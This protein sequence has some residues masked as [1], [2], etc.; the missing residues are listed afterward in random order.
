MSFKPARLNLFDPSNVDKKFNIQVGV[1]N[2]V[3]DPNSH[4]D[5]RAA[6]IKYGDDEPVLI[7]NL[8]AENFENRNP[9]AQLSSSEEGEEG[10]LT[11][12]LN[13]QEAEVFDENKLLYIASS[14]E[15]A[16]VSPSNVDQL[17]LQY[18]SHNVVGNNLVLNGVAPSS[19]NRIFTP[20]LTNYVLYYKSDIKEQP[21]VNVM[22]KLEDTFMM[23]ENHF[24]TM[25]YAERERATAAEGV[26]HSVSNQNALAI[27][28]EVSRATEKDEEHAQDIADEVLRAKAAEEV[29][30]L[31]I[32]NIL[33][34][35]DPAA[36]DSLAE[37]VAKMDADELSLSGL[38]T[39]NNT[40]IKSNTANIASNATDIASNAT[41]ISG[42]T[43]RAEAAE[44]KNTDDIAEEKKRAEAAEQ[45]N[46]DAIEEEVLRATLKETILTQNL[47]T[48][49]SRAIAKDDEHTA[50]ITSNTTNITSNTTNI[51]SNTANITSNTTDIDNIKQLLASF[52]TGDQSLFDE[53]V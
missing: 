36:L 19:P 6:V 47:A 49:V 45:K 37:I 15:V 4:S 8:C 10:T 5:L 53:L 2:V 11:M 21:A 3:S 38:I 51:T 24:S 40:E 20:N 12:Q 7:K 42:E 33:Q 22:D 28:A 41:N 27:A 9:I 30:A 29:N 23:A 26:I 35:S 32:S 43:G 44:Q 25:L 52:F 34:N 14:Q 31:A 48:E 17:G 46:T 16:F 18:S 1:T 13:L 50:N 39:S